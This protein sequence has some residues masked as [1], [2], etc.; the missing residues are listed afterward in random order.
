MSS[1][2]ACTPR[3]LQVFSVLFQMTKFSPGAV[4]PAGLSRRGT[5][6]DELRH[7]AT[8]LQHLDLLARGQLISQFWEFG[9]GLLPRDGH[10][11]ASPL[12]FVLPIQAAWRTAMA[13]SFIIEFRR[14]PASPLRQKGIEFSPDRAIDK[15]AGGGYVEFRSRAPLPWT[16]APRCFFLFRFDPS[17][18]PRLTSCPIG[19]T[20][21]CSRIARPF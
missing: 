18:S 15:L 11:N 8:P 16:P 1:L 19:T 3:N 17:T 14:F 4:R 21:I 12:S 2:T 20:T 6:V 13:P 10:H 5:L 7:G 9:L